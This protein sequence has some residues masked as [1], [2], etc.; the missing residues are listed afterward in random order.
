MPNVPDLQ[1]DECS[2]SRVLGPG[3]SGTVYPAH[4]TLLYGAVSVKALTRSARTDADA[5]SG[6]Y[7][8]AAGTTGCAFACA[9][10]SQAHAHCYSD[11]DEH[12]EIPF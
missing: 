2:V 1:P 5:H 6:G 4:V 11:D 12:D 3:G 8:H 10:R 9:P 7:G